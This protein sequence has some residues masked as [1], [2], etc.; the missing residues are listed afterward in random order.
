MSWS[1]SNVKKYVP[2]QVHF[3]LTTRHW[4]WLDLIHDPWS[5]CLVFWKLVIEARSH[6]S[7]VEWLHSR[8]GTQELEQFKAYT[9]HFYDILHVPNIFTLYQ[10]RRL[11]YLW[12]SGSCFHKVLSA[13][14]KTMIRMLNKD[15]SFSYDFKDVSLNIQVRTS[16]PTILIEV[17]K[18]KEI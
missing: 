2:N 1:I 11:V 16:G 18:I 14:Q 8:I 3:K 13:C 7:L 15:V 4:A 9:N 6:E 12:I 10:I 5:N 17:S